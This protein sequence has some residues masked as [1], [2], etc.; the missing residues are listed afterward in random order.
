M[1][2][3]EIARSP[4]E[5]PVPST[6]IATVS[7]PTALPVKLTLPEPAGV[8]PTRVVPVRLRNCPSLT[9]PIVRSVGPLVSCMATT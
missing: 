5:V 7:L 2:E 6:K 9:A 1:N 3:L 4:I 8:A